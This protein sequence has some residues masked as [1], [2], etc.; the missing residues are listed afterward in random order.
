[1]KTRTTVTLSNDLLKIID[2]QTGEY[3]NRS[4]FIE[5]ALRSFLAQMHHKR[6]NKKDLQIIN[7]QADHL[8]REAAEVL[9]YQVPL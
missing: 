8:N 3:K 7:Q 1:M 5:N 6:R 4:A 2:Q 9:E